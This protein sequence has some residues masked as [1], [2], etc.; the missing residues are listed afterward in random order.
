MRQLAILV[1]VPLLFHL[2]AASQQPE[3][4]PQAIA[5]LQNSAAAMGGSAWAAI[6]DWTITGSMSIS[7][8][9]Q[10]PSNFSWI[11][12]GAEFR[13]E[14]DT[15]QTKNLFLS[16]HGSPVR[17][18]NGTVSP[19]NY[20]VARANPPLYVPGVRLTQELNNQQLTIQY[21]GDQTGLLYQVEC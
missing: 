4:D 6:Q 14:K 21:V 2:D 19:I 20:F 8:S 16:G 5:V 18:T 11:G 7:G 3:Q 13:F 1:I 10:S 9:G 12:A 15:G 17:I